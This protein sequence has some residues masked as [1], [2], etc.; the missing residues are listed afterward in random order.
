MN[1]TQLIPLQ[2][3]P[4]HRP[5]VEC[6]VYYCM[7]AHCNCRISCVRLFFQQ[8]ALLY[9][10]S[11]RG[12]N[13]FNFCLCVRL[14]VCLLMCLVMRTI[15]WELANRGKDQTIILFGNKILVHVH[16]EYLPRAARCSTA[17]GASCAITSGPLH[18]D[19]LWLPSSRFVM[20]KKINYK[21]Y[22]KYKF[23]F[24]W[25]LL[26]LTFPKDHPS[27]FY[28]HPKEAQSQEECCCQFSVVLPFM[29]LLVSRNGR[30]SPPTLS[31]RLPIVL[32][33]PLLFY[34]YKFAI[35]SYSSWSI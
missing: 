15:F 26:T 23:I 28:V 1:I 7:P 3:V 4:L 2:V 12:F 10:V 30:K 31:W 6:A 35:T 19:P 13:N 18:W 24:F 9:S 32:F 33:S 20:K 27:N 5:F 25:K 11:G 34:F 14:F 29:L 8:L 16:I 22:L 17:Y 21:I